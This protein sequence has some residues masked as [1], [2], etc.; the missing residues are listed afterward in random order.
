MEVGTCDVGKEGRVGPRC[1]QGVASAEL[2]Q[3]AR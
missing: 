1:T 2:T 3:Q